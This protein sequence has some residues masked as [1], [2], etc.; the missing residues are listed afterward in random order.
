MLLCHMHLCA[1]HEAICVSNEAA[2]RRLL[3]HNATDALRDYFV[4]LSQQLYMRTMHALAMLA[5]H[6]ISLSHVA[7]CVQK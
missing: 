6:L 3:L 5:A 1:L 4:K 2:Q 7:H